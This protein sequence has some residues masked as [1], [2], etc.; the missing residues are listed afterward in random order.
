MGRKPSSKKEM[1]GVD[2]ARRVLGV[3]AST[4]WRLL[5]SGR[6]PSIRSGGRR[7]IPAAA[8]Q[9]TKRKRAVPVFTLDNPI[10]KL[11]GAAHG[12]GRKPGSS[13]KHAILDE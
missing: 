7:L 8:L 6:I 11:I 5:K 9:R 3:S 1:V 13:D 12:D 2:E 4:V 10:F